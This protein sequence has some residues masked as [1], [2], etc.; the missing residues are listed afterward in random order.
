M[1]DNYKCFENVFK[2]DW[3]VQGFNATP[4]FLNAAA[5]S[6]IAMKKILGYGYQSFFFHYHQGYGE[7]GYLQSDIK[8]IWKI[9][10]K[11]IAVDPNYLKKIKEKQNHVAEK[12]KRVFKQIDKLN[13]KKI[14]NIELITFLHNTIK[15]LINSVGSAHI[16]EPI[17]IGIEKEFKRELLKAIGPIKEFNHHYALLT[18]QTQSS[19][20][21]QEE[22]ELKSSIKLPLSKRKIAL[23]KHCSKYFWLRNSYAKPIYLTENDFIKRSKVLDK[24]KKVNINIK[25]QKDNLISKLKLNLVNKN[26]IKIIDFTSLWQDKRKA[27][28]L[29]AVGYLGKIVHELARRLKIKPEIL[30][31]LGSQEALNIKSV[32][33]IELMKTKLVK[34]KKN[35]FVLMQGNK[36]YISQPRD[37]QKILKLKQFLI[38]KQSQQNGA[39]HGSIAN[40]GTAVGRAV[41]CKGIKSL[42]NVRQGDVLV[43]S[44][45]RPEFMP[46]LKKVVAIVTDEGGVTCHAAI[47]ARELNIPAV[48]GTKYS[49]KVLKDGMIVEVKGSHGIVNIIG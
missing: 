22:Q 27:D 34:R 46:A 4:L 35:T 7:M 41:V 33:E 40:T 6:G 45:T 16:I 1:T 32:K 25:K 9:V 47:M 14:D 43:A 3:Y 2:K 15:G 19:F 36:E 20:F 28:I 23:K 17:G 12:N 13:L 5:Y 10:K 29:I 30:Y 38:K 39:I 24:R 26:R 21:A 44:M 8:G 49:T 42:I 31:Y 37:A 11:N 48:I 18:T